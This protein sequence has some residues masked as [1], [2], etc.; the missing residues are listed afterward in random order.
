M[1]TYLAKRTRSGR[2][3]AVGA[4]ADLSHDIGTRAELV[5][6]DGTQ[7]ATAVLTGV[8]RIW[9]DPDTGTDQAYG[10]MDARSQSTA[11]AA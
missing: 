2:V 10:Y 1:H 8:G 5:A 4:P 3:V 9:S 11:G 6:P 7:T